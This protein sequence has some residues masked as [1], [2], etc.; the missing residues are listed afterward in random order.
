[1]GEVITKDTGGRVQIQVKIGEGSGPALEPPVTDP[2][3]KVGGKDRKMASRG[4]GKGSATAISV[5]G[6]RDARGQSDSV[7]TGTD[8]EGSETDQNKKKKAAEKPEGKSNM[9][10][11]GGQEA[12]GPGAPGLLVG[13]I[14]SAHQEP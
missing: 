2:E 7:D 4:N 11:D 1:M 8:E 12:T 14:D 9:G 13:A 6:K 5:L 10:K 3:E